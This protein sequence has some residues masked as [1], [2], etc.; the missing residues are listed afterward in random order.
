MKNRISLRMYNDQAYQRIGN[1]YLSKRDV[2]ESAPRSNVRKCVQNSVVVD[3][4]MASDLI[5]T[6]DVNLCYCN[7]Y[8]F[9]WCS[10]S[11]SVERNS[12]FCGLLWPGSL[13]YCVTRSMRNAKFTRC[14]IPLTWALR[15]SNT[16][17]VP[18]VFMFLCVLTNEE[19]LRGTQDMI[20]ESR[21]GIRV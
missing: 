15:G 10:N 3:I 17:C 2:C 13:C 21:K 6:V 8:C 1:G 9:R 4:E 19:P 7:H 14:A 20:N 11:N 18:V 12:T 16:V 5:L